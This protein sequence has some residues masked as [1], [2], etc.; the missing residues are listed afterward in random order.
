MA[1]YAGNNASQLRLSRSMERTMPPD[2]MP[3]PFLSLN[4][5]FAAT[6]VEAAR[7]ECGVG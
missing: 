2:D 4:T 7:P 3:A 5:G 6:A 1:L